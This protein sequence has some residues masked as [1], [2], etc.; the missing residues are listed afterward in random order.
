[1]FLKNRGKN[2]GDFEEL[3]GWELFRQSVLG[4][5]SY[6]EWG[7]GDSTCYVNDNYNCSVQVAENDKKWAKKIGKMTDENVK[8]F[9]IDL[10]EVGNW[11]RPVGFKKAGSFAS[12]FLAPFSDGFSP[13]VILIDGRFRVACFM[14]ALLHA[15]PGAVIIFDDYTRRPFYHV[16]EEVLRPVKIDER[17]ARFIRPNR[18]DETAIAEMLKKFEYVMD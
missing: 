12:Y 10:G 17:Q 15:K 9:H 4:C 8:I 5:E 11:G 6:A 2:R 1:M 7:S 13:D 16:V 14:T 18:V 3:E